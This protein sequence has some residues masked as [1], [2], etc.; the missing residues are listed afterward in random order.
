MRHLFISSLHRKCRTREGWFSQTWNDAFFL[1]GAGNTNLGDWLTDVKIKLDPPDFVSGE[2]ENWKIFFSQKL[3]TKAKR[4]WTSIK[5]GI[6]LVFWNMLF[7]GVFWWFYFCKL[8]FCSD[9]STT[10]FISFISECKPPFFHI[11]STSL[12]NCLCGSPQLGDLLFTLGPKCVIN[13]HAQALRI[14]S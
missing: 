9:W 3:C 7:F 10:E 11:Q 4:N 5:K 14:C 6:C 1:S 2:A 13:E 12:G 8:N